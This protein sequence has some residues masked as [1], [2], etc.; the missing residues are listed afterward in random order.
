MENGEF[1]NL[2][3]VDN[4]IKHVIYDGEENLI[5]LATYNTNYLFG[6]SDY[7]LLAVIGDSA[8]FLKD[9]NVFLIFQNGMIYQIKYKNYEE[10]I[11]EEK[12]QFP[13]AELTPQKKVN[14][15]ID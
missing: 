5:S 11:A 7:G 2:L 3:R 1:T 10:L 8:T 13:D 15:N 9:R 12:R 14:Y 6:T 4:T